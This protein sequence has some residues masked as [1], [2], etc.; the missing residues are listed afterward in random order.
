[1]AIVNHAAG[2]EVGM[3]QSLNDLNLFVSVLQLTVGY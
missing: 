3:S 2:G 1:M